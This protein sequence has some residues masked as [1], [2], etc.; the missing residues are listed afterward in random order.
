LLR[1]LLAATCIAVLN[2]VTA[3]LPSCRRHTATPH[4]KAAAA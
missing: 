1:M 3:L 2:C 4:V